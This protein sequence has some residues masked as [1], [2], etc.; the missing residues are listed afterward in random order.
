LSRSNPFSGTG[1]LAMFAA[2]RRAYSRWKAS[3]WSGALNPD[4]HKKALSITH[5]AQAG[6]PGGQQ[7]EVSDGLCVE[8]DADFELNL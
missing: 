5:Q 1:S 3:L 2:M 4:Q 6:R 8:R 7:T